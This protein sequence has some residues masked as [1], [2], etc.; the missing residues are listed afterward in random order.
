ML[1]GKPGRSPGTSMPGTHTG[2]N[3]ERPPRG[4]LVARAA[5]ATPGRATTRVR[6]ARCNAGPAAGAVPRCSRSTAATSTSSPFHPGSSARNVRNDLP[7]ISVAASSTLVA[8]TCTPTRPE[9][10]RSSRGEA[11]A[12]PSRSAGANSNR[13]DRSAGRML[14]ASAVPMV[15]TTAN[16]S[17]APSMPR[18]APSRPGRATG[19]VTPRTNPTSQV[20][21]ITP[22]AP[23]AAKR[24]PTS[25]R[26][27]RASRPSPAPIA[28][29]TANSRWRSEAR[30]RR[31]VVTLRHAMP[32][33]R[34]TSTSST[35]RN[36]AT[37][38]R[39]NAGRGP[40]ASTC[41]A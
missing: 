33:A 13:P 21:A 24:M 22:I 37:G 6:M 15:R 29:R 2:P 32:S 30:A 31:T 5:P 11:D 23:A 7:A 1:A 38:P 17:T 16:S 27:W 3:D 20:A 39:A 35:P 4:N 41:T 8:A 28:R 9:R 26:I 10:K 36:A 19:E 25:V 18:S 12:P 14:N 40:H 34:P